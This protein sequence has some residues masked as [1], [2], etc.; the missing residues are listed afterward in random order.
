MRSS[1]VKSGALTLVAGIGGRYHF[2]GK[3]R[4]LPF[5]SGGAGLVWT[6]LDVAEIDR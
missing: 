4:V 2:R 1:Q 6:S 5:V 3:G